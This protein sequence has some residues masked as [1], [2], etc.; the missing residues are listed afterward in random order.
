[1]D[2]L[3]AARLWLA[4]PENANHIDPVIF[5]V[6]RLLDQMSVFLFLYGPSMLH[7]HPDRLDDVKIWVGLFGL[8]AVTAIAWRARRTGRHWWPLHGLLAVWFV[9][10][11]AAP[12]LDQSVS[13]CDPASEAT[14]APT[15]P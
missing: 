2:F 13:S 4:T 12:I 7:L 14:A 10:A 11:A 1:M 5:F 8:V 15:S 6:P 9:A 3:A